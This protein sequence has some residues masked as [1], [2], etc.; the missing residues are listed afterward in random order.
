MYTIHCIYFV[1]YEFFFYSVFLCVKYVC[2]LANTKESLDSGIALSIME[3]YQG[4]VEEKLNIISS[5]ELM[6]VKPEKVEDQDTEREKVVEEKG[7]VVNDGKQL[8]ENI[9]KGGKI[10]FD[11]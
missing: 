4:F 1:L 2:Y 5:F 3:I 8:E 10:F 7:E 6:E 9:Y 11:L